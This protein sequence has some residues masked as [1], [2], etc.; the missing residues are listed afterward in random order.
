LH[1][2]CSKAKAISSRIGSLHALPK[3]ETPTGNSSI[4]PIGTVIFGYPDI[5]ARDEFPPM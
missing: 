3:K 4:K 5:A 1:K 2:G